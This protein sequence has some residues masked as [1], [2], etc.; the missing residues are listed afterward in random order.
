MAPAAATVTQ[1]GGVTTAATSA[2]G[3]AGRIRSKADSSSLTGD[4]GKAVWEGVEGDGGA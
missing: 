2:K 3:A 1:G 4:G